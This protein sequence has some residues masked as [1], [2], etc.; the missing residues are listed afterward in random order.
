[1]DS[2]SRG[3][4]KHIVEQFVNIENASINEKEKEEEKEKKYKCKT[5]IVRIHEQ[6]RF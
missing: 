5:Q 2:L 3:N 6:N 1:M 4:G